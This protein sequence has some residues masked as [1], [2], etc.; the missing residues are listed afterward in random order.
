MDG[1]GQTNVV[2][3]FLSTI[4]N[5]EEPQLVDDAFLDEHLFAIST[6]VPWFVDVENYLVVGK[7]LRHLKSR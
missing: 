4:I 3:D 2:V 6:N 7:L 1:P 5:N